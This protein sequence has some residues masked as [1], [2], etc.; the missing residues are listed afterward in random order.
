MGL[1]PNLETRIAIIKKKIELEAVTVPDDVIFFIAEK[2]KTDVRDLE[3]LLIRIVA[4]SLLENKPISL[5]L[6]HKV[7][8]LQKNF[9][10]GEDFPKEDETD[11]G[12][13]GSPLN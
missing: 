2:V 8:K 13:Y 5:E 7:F 3:G 10:Y 11:S 12:S 1:I 6:A 4:Y 9:V